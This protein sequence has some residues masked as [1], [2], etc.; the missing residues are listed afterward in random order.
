[1]K[2]LLYKNLSKY[3]IEILLKNSTPNWQKYFN[4]NIDLI[5]DGGA[6][7][8]SYL[9]GGLLYLHHISDY[10]KINRISATST[11][12]LFGLLYLSNLLSKY[13]YKFYKKFRKCFKTKGNLSVLKDCLEF[14][15]KNISCDFYLRCNKVFYVT[16]F[17][18]STKKQVVRYTYSSN[19]D[20]ISCI[21]KSCY[22]P[23]LID[24]KLSF[25][26]KYI[27][28]LVPFIFAKNNTKTLFMD[29]H[30][31]YLSKM[32]NIKNE[33]NNHSRIL[34]GIF[35]THRFF[36]Y[37]KSNLCFDIYNHYYYYK[38]A[39]YIRQNIAVKIVYLIS[40]LQCLLN[41]NLKKNK[42]HIHIENSSIK[43]LYSFTINYLILHLKKILPFLIKLLINYYLI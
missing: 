22:I 30:S 18:I 29:L 43:Q 2:L 23:F 33:L 21:Y 11:G 34:T 38:I 36:M 13:N 25:E 17:D 12:S 8:G 32:I 5:L 42:N 10:I 40:L 41:K 39:F 3:F 4:S 20:L 28:G 15:K 37:G 9:L 24:N 26:N 1:M 7:S 35:E 27:D 31:N 16:Y 19:N 14:I 6:F